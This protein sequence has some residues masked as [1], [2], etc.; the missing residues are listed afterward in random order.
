MGFGRA[1]AF[2]QGSFS[3]PSSVKTSSDRNA[4]ARSAATRQIAHK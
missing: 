2:E 4:I 1:G 3:G